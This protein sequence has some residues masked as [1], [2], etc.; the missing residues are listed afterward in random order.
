MGS[1]QTRLNRVKLF[2]FR[3]L[4]LDGTH[5]NKMSVSDKS[6]LKTEESVWKGKGNDNKGNRKAAFAFLVDSK[7]ASEAGD[8]NA[9]DMASHGNIYIASLF[10]RFKVDN[11][12]RKYLEIFVQNFSNERDPDSF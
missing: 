6:K 1:F 8:K 9:L 4:N 2:Q 3:G 7:R 12:A 11:S 5:S 10:G